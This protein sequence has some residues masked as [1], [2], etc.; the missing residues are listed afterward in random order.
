MVFA[1]PFCMR[2]TTFVDFH[3][4]P[5]MLF[6]LRLPDLLHYTIGVFYTSAKASLEPHAKRV[7]F[8]IQK[9]T[10]PPIRGDTVQIIDQTDE[11]V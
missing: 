7:V 9:N 10:V 4:R 8:V 6:C 3:K 1:I 5:P 2:C 11:R